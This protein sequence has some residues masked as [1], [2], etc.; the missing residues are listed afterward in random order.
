ME[1]ARRYGG[2]AMTSMF[3]YPVFLFLGERD[4]FEATRSVAL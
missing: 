4:E 2:N 1:E 3:T